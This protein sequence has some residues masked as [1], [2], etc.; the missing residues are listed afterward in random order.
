MDK[1]TKLQVVPTGVTKT[2]P[3]ISIG[4]ITAAITAV[5]ALLVAY[6]V[7]ISQEQQVAILGVAAVVAPVVVGIITR[8]NVYSPASAQRAA[9]E[10]AATGDATIA[11]PPATN[12]A[13]KRAA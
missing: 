1:H 9:N 2:E 8:F 4:S 5:L 10:A 6:G 7:D 11:P 12:G 3:A 13:H